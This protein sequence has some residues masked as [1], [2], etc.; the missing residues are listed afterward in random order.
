[1]LTN[2][3]IKI[4]N[5]FFQNPKL[6]QEYATEINNR[7]EILV[8]M[9][10]KDDTDKTIDEKLESIKTIIK[11]TKQQRMEKDGSTKNIKK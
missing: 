10:G 6:K 4:V 5:I 8:N 9:D 1:V 3:K 7:S 2:E 11:E